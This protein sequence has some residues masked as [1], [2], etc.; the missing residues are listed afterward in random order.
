MND[1][2]LN[3]FVV[4]LERKISKMVASMIE[5]MIEIRTEKT[6]ITMLKL[7]T[8]HTILLTV[9]DSQSLVICCKSTC[10][11]CEIL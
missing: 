8:F 5:L 3:E 6:E 1:E 9:K 7:L 2:I 10:I 11:A 4:T